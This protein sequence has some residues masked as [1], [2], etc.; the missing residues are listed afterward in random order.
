MRMTLSVLF[1]WHFEYVLSIQNIWTVKA[2]KFWLNRTLC[3]ICVMRSCREKTCFNLCSEKVKTSRRICEVSINPWLS[4]EETR[5]DSI[6]LNRRQRVINVHT[7]QRIPKAT[8]PRCGLDIIEWIS[9]YHINMYT[10]VQWGSC[11]EVNA[12][13]SS[14][15]YWLKHI[16][17]FS[18]SG[19]NMS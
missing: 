8:D 3:P 13:Y 2:F 10:R 11:D 1:D 15:R 18:F 17:F 7:F 4:V 9:N 14:R 16:L 6:F 12:C 5:K 19:H